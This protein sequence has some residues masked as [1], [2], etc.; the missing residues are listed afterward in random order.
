MAADGR[1]P[2]DGRVI[3]VLGTNTATG[4]NAGSTAKRDRIDYWIGQGAQATDAVK[5][6]IKPL[7]KAAAEAPDA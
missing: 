5:R 1:A 7:R 2:R 3:G 6:V 4:T